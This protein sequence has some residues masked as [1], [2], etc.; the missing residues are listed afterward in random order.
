[1]AD[2]A[3][4]PAAV[5]RDLAAWQR[6]DVDE[7][8][9]L[10][11]EVSSRNLH[12][13]NATCWVWTGQT[14]DGDPAW[15]L[16]VTTD[17]ARRFA[18]QGPARVLA[19]LIGAAV[20]IGADPEASYLIDWHGYA[21]LVAPGL[22]SDL[23][24][25][26]IAEALPAPAR[27][28]AAA[29]PERVH[30]DGDPIALDAVRAPGGGVAALARA[31]HVHPVRVVLSL[32]AHGQPVDD[33]AYPPELS[34]SLREWGCAGEPPP[35][36]EASLDIED[37]PCPRRRHA[38]KVLQRLLRMRKIG[39]QYHTEFDHIYRGAPAH[40]RR[41]ALE[42]GEA[43]IRAGILGEKPSVGQR[44]VYLRREALPDIHALIDR[45]E[46]RDPLLAA[47]WTAPPPGFVSKVRV[48]TPRPS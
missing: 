12:A 2:L 7:A 20:E 5:A 16:P 1:V 46:T 21:C 27:G 14:P 41:D 42:V 38:R 22:E 13:R 37:D 33:D 19:R 48:H 29:L 6:G 34:T 26:A 28:A 36:P 32:A 9:R 31:N 30:L 47:E 40:E 4:D 24:R 8:A 17:A 43:L 45:G 23:A 44:H 18:P 39:D 3:R 35:P 15:A 25:E 11:L 10:T